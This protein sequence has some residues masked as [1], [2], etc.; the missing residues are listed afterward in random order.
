MKKLLIFDLDG[1]LADTIN[2][3]RH[4]V[5]LAMAHFGYSERSYEEVRL[6][7]GDGARVLIK[8]TLPFEER[9][10]DETVDTVLA[11]YEKMY[12][13]THMEADRCY[14]KMAQ[15]LAE[16]HKR[17]YKIAVLSNKQDV[18][19]RS[20][21]AKIVERGIVSLAMGQREGYPRK[22]DATVPLIITES[23]GFSPEDTVFI[24]DSEVDVLTAKNAGMMSIGCSWGYRGRAVLEEYGADFIVDT[25]P[26][27]LDILG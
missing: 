24:G 11:Y 9:E 1:T 13:I 15:T 20:I 22:P 17:G 2:S 23:L 8:R 27:L 26:Q 5:N 7:I 16:L 25:P 12:D 21:V 14:D 18:Y 6:A 19:V 10:N 3:I 4:A